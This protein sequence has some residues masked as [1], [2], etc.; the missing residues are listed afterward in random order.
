MP[1]VMAS[2]V[3]P[4]VLSWSVILPVTAVP[5]HDTRLAAFQVQPEHSMVVPTTDRAAVGLAA[6]TLVT[7]ANVP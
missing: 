4:Y 2:P 5:S 6:S 1:A 7:V 3:E